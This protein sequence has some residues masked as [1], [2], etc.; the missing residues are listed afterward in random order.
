[1]NPVLAIPRVFSLLSLFIYVFSIVLS[2]LV[3][4]V[5][6]AGSQSDYVLSKDV[7]VAYALIYL[8]C[9][10]VLRPLMNKMQYGLYMQYAVIST[11]AD[12]TDQNSY[13]TQREDMTSQRHVPTTGPLTKGLGPREFLSDFNKH[14]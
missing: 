3:H 1:V 10:L 8:A 5:Y 14:Y 7:I 4:L 2:S 13:A 9:L 12:P 6:V 11:D